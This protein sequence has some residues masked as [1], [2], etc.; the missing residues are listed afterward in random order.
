MS[1][2]KSYSENKTGAGAAQAVG[3]GAKATNVAIKF[4]V[5]L[6]VPMRPSKKDT[7]QR[8]VASLLCIIIGVS[9]ICA[10]SVLPDRGDLRLSRGPRS[11]FVPNQ[12]AWRSDPA[13]VMSMQYLREMPTF[14][15]QVRIARYSAHTQTLYSLGLVAALLG[16]GYLLLC[17]NHEMR[18]GADAD[19]WR[20]SK[21]TGAI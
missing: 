16:V 10:A 1:E 9:S 21:G 18:C 6:F 8:L 5:N 15:E 13:G 3:D 20:K 19:S 12:E 11:T 2:P 4:I 7:A 17:I 14:D